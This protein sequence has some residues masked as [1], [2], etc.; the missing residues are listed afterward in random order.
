MAAAVILAGALV[1][2]A[3]LYA[4]QQNHRCDKWN[5]AMTY[6]RQE[7]TPGNPNYLFRGSNEEDANTTGKVKLADGT[8]VTRPRGCS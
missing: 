8:L 2:G 7:D 4:N 3:L 6:A 5:A 1:A